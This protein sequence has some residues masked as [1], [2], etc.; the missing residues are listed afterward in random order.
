M[1]TAL[2]NN[3]HLKG[4]DTPDTQ[5]EC[6]QI[7]RQIDVLR[8][9][10]SRHCN[11]HIDRKFIG[12]DSSVLVQKEVDHPVLQDWQSPLERYFHRGKPRVVELAGEQQLGYAHVF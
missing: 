9:C 1:T 8:N 12:S 7:W 2:V 10:R 11:V 5:R 3:E 6:V 4:S